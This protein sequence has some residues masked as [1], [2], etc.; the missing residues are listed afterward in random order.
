MAKPAAI[1][2]WADIPEALDTQLKARA[3]RTGRTRDQVVVAAIE[4]YLERY[5]PE[6][7][8]KVDA[9][10]NAAGQQT[11]ARSVGQGGDEFCFARL[12]PINH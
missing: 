4:A 9:E 12:S 8:E 11:P 6:L 3:K 1:R 10:A 5:D 2:I 7:P